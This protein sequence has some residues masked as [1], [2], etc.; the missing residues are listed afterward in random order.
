M[1]I[2]KMLFGASVFMINSAHETFYTSLDQFIGYNK[3]QQLTD[4]FTLFLY[5]L[6]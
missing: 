1:K 6:L 3:A 2:L 4:V 5:T